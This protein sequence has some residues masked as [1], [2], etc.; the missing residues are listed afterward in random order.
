MG[1]VDMNIRRVI[2]SGLLLGSCGVCGF[3][4]LHATRKQ[5]H[6]SGLGLNAKVLNF[7]E[8]PKE[9]EAVP[10]AGVPIGEP[11]NKSRAITHY[12]WKIG[13]PTS[14]GNIVFA[15]WEQ[16]HLDL[17][18]DYGFMLINEGTYEHPKA[19]YLLGYRQQKRITAFHTFAKFKEALKGI[20]SGTRVYL[21]TVCT[22]GTAPGVDEK[23]WK[24]VGSA[25]HETYLRFNADDNN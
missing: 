7:A 2:Y 21:H 13:G 24:A 8:S 9:P 19:V 23:T 4:L 6:V 1:G 22:A 15:D 3:V 5:E 25:F 11:T 14:E 12:K 20:P 18:S 16:G 17:L 10:L